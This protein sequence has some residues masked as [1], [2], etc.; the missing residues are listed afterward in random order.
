MYSM[1]WLIGRS[2]EM[3]NIS[4]PGRKYDDV[5][6]CFQVSASGILFF[7]QSHHLLKW[8]KI[9]KELE[10]ALH[11]MYSSIFRIC[12]YTLPCEAD[13]RD[14]GFPP[15]CPMDAGNSNHIPNLLLILSNAF[16]EDF[17]NHIKFSAT[18]SYWTKPAIY[19]NLYLKLKKSNYTVIPRPAFNSWYLK[20][21]SNNEIDHNIRIFV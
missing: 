16:S 11:H 12:L 5:Q 13:R 15:H 9:G 20:Q 2:H 18:E 19:F 3:Y 17:L 6:F 7:P 21:F 4:Y 8:V 14:W 10:R 1:G